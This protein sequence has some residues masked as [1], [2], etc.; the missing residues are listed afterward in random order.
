M[1]LDI[2]VNE[3][4]ILNGGLGLEMTQMRVLSVQ[5]ITLARRKVGRFSCR[6][7]VAPFIYFFE[8][9]GGILVKSGCKYWI[10][11]HRRLVDVQDTN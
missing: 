7:I 4:V 1:N 5:S 6:I 9:W 8:F 2:R 11:V 10:G 3:L